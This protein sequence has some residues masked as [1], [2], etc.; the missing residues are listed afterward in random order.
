LISQRLYSAVEPLIEAESV[1]EL[2]FKGI[3][4]PLQ[5]YNILRLRA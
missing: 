3:H 5:T 4:R 2:S 1:G